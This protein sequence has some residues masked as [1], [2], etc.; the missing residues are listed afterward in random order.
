MPDDHN[1]EASF[2]IDASP[3]RLEEAVALN[4]HVWMTTK[5]RAGGGE[6]HEEKGVTWIFTPG[7]ESEGM[8]LFPRLTEANASTQLDEIIHFYRACRPEK[9]VGCWSLYPT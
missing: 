9:L 8:I 2:L 6:I 4:H 1:S 7:R 5:T 3:D